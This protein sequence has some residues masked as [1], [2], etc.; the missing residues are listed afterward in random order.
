APPEL[1][2]QVLPSKID[3]IVVN[4]LSWRKVLALAG[5]ARVGET[6]KNKQ[7]LDEF[8]S[9]LTE[10]LDMEKKRSNMVYV[11]SLSKGSSWGLSFKDVVY[12]DGRYFYPVEGGRWPEPPNY[13]AYRYDGQL[14]S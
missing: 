8:C 6:N 1:A 10:I 9:Y 12:R 14:Q 7:L 2:G 5:L 11:L 4:H 3:G 13:V